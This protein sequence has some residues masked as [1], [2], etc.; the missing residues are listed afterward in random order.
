MGVRRLVAILVENHPG[1]LTRVAGL[2]A[3]RGFNIDSVAVGVTDVPGLSRMTIGVEGDEATVEQVTKQLN[4]LIQVLKV[5]DLDP[6]DAVERELALIK[7]NAEPSRR[8]QILQIVDI[9]RAKVV[10]VGPK[11]LVVEISGTG[12][13]VEAL[14]TMLREFGVKEVVRTGAIALERGNRLVRYEREEEE[15]S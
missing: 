6:R 12:D 11:S 9:F 14:L 4:K 1:V 15:V 2:F 3:R 5:V 13:K 8:T 10:D 7:V